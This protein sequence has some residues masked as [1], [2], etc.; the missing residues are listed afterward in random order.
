M[1]Q[2]RAIGVCFLPHT[3]MPDMLAPCVTAKAKNTGVTTVSGEK[4]LDAAQILLTDLRAGLP[5]TEIELRREET[6]S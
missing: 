5:G 3:G 1:A 4:T 6:R 2:M